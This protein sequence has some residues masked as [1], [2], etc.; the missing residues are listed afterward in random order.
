MTLA[1]LQNRLRDLVA[2]EPLLAG[3]PVLIEDKQNLISAIE[4][5]LAETSLCVVIAPVSG[6][7]KVS[8]QPQAS[9]VLPRRAA[10]GEILE[11][12]LFRGLIDAA[13]VP[14]T[15]AVLDALRARLHGAPL[16]ADQSY[17]GTFAFVSHNLRD[18]EDG[19]YVR[20]LTFAA[21]VTIS[22]PAGV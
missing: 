7:A 18:Q 11:I 2:A 1:D 9:S 3:R 12:S 21:T 22:P 5:A 14:S 4:T 20:V 15:V 16:T 10:V 19:T 6:Q 13:D 8:T 17:R